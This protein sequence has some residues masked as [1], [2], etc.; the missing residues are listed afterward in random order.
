MFTTVLALQQL[1][2]G[3]INLNDTVDTYLPDFARVRVAWLA[4]Q[5]SA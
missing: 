4:G 5:R 2:E 3:L 1:G